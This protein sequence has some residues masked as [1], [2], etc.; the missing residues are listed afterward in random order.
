MQTHITQQEAKEVKEAGLLK[1]DDADTEQVIVSYLTASPEQLCTLRESGDALITKLDTIVASA[2][3][4]TTCMVLDE[5][6][7]VVGSHST[8]HADNAENT[9]KTRHVS[10][11]QM[12]AKKK[13]PKRK[14]NR[15][16]T[17]S[18]RTAASPQLK[19]LHTYKQN[20][21]LL[22]SKMGLRASR[23]M[24]TVT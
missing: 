7:P 1:C 12:Y 4:H 21:V 10:Q 22:A 3:P 20:L 16:S 6:I 17:H 18:M 15:L 19:V 5:S 13:K 24:S 8:T 2:K 9:E 23:T 14:K 11:A